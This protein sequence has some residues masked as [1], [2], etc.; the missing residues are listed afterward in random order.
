ME[1]KIYVSE[2]ITVDEYDLIIHFS[3]KSI[4]FYDN[5]KRLMS[6]NVKTIIYR[7]KY[8]IGFLNLVDERV[9]GALFMDIFI[10]EEY[11]NRG[12]AALAYKD[13]EKKYDKDVF[14]IAQTK[15]DNIGA[16][17]S[18]FKNGT[19]IK[20]KDDMNF[21]L[22]NKSREEEFLNSDSYD[23]FVSHFGLNSNKVYIKK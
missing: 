21:Y 7:N 15:K 18:L 19:L 22:M 5:Y 11:R 6:S 4:V 1:E 8:P 2:A 20:E 3:K 17:L 14:I 23:S 10:D 13:L 16:N 12:Y 9:N